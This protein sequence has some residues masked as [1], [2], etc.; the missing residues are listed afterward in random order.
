MQEFF[1]GRETR[2]DLFW[3]WWDVGSSRNG[4]AGF[5]NPILNPAKTSGRCLVTLNAPHEFF[6]QLAGKPD[7]KW[8][9]LEAR[10]SMLESHDVIADFP[11]I[12]GTAIYDLSCLRGKHPAWP[13]CLQSCSIERLHA[14]QMAGSKY[15]DGEGD[16]LRALIV[17]LAGLHPRVP[18]SAAVSTSVQEAGAPAQ[19][20]NSCPVILSCPECW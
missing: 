17:R 11:K 7:A 9:F 5:A 13:V 3:R 16:L 14:V 1:P 12:L 6:V 8:E 20:L 15:E 19:R 2:L 18:Q 10:D 4:T